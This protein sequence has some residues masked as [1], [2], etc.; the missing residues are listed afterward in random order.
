MPT[1]ASP[2]LSPEAVVHSS[3]ERTSVVSDVEDSQGHDVLEEA[4]ELA[5]PAWL[6]QLP[7]ER[8]RF[9]DGGL[10]RATR[11]MK[12][13][14]D[15]VVAAGLLVLT[16]PIVMVAAI[17]IKATSPGS[18]IF[19]QVRVGL[20]RR[21]YDRSGRSA[22]RVCRRKKA[23]FG[24]PFV[25][26]KLRTMHVAADGDGP[27]TAQKDDDRVFRVGRFLRRTRIDELPQLINVLK[28]EMSMVGP[29]PECIDYMEDLTSKFPDYAERL[30]L[31]P[32]LTGIAQIEA[33]PPF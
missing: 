6:V 31:K 13:G 30:R 14:L 19:R 8:A 21:R 28:G 25:I 23:N 4:P 5:P 17:A 26:Y 9:Q 16:M 1:V 24:R 2:V 10:P 20:N 15:I 12:R 18:V 33:G 32:G 27:R 11:W 3:D 29:R 7:D 22:V